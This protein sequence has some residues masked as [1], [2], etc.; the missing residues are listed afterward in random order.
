MNKNETRPEA[1]AY[2]V[3]DCSV[4]AL[5]ISTG[6]PY[7]QVYRV[8]KEHGRKPKQG[9]DLHKIMKSVCK[10][11]KVTARQ[12]KRSGSLRGFVNK[13][14]IGVYVCTKR[15]HAFAVVNGVVSDDTK[16]DCHIKR[17]WKIEQGAKI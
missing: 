8:F 12:V 2:E 10:D 15:G 13:F 11:L 7:E 9:V 6:L 5:T 17:A 14:P 3:R 16:P 1:Y 4:R